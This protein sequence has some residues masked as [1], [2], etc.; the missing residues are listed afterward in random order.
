M[1]KEG[2]LYT[3]DRCNKEQFIETSAIR[4]S[5]HMP[6]DWGTHKDKHLCPVCAGLYND[7]INRFFAPEVRR[8]LDLE[9]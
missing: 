8:K 1:L 3:C 9:V 5:D 7:A 6:L 4:N 2:T